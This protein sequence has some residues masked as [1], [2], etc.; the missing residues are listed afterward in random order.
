MDGRGPCVESVM[1]ENV[2]GLRPGLGT[3]V[4]THTKDVRTHAQMYGPPHKT[5]G[6]SETGPDTITRHCM[7]TIDGRTCQ[8]R[9]AQAGQI[10]GSYCIRT[11]R[12]RDTGNVHTYTLALSMVGGGGT[13]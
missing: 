4:R 12:V 6:P 10:T 1:R 11:V 2:L 3:D 5:N 8:D 7:E 13:R 9:S